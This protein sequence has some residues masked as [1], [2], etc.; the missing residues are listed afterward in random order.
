MAR[1]YMT[2][3]AYESYFARIS[4]Y[5]GGLEDSAIIL[6]EQLNKTLAYFNDLEDKQDNV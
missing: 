5:V 3:A 4:G 1:I 6:R 2:S